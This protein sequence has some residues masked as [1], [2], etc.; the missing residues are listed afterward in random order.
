MQVLSY[1]GWGK[2]GTMIIITMSQA[3]H[4]DPEGGSTTRGS[5]IRT[6]DPVDKSVKISRR[7]GTISKILLRLIWGG[8]SRN[9][10]VKEMGE[11]FSL[12]G[13]GQKKQLNI[14]LIQKCVPCVPC[15]C[16]GRGKVD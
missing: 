13:N 5:E 15:V 16:V 4:G 14:E 11:G 7:K 2:G 9:N 8:G 10:W 3:R 12:G 1:K 6:T